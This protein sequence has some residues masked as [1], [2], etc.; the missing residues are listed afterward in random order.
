MNQR[1]IIIRH[2]ANDAHNDVII[3]RHRRINGQFKT[4]IN[5]R[6]IYVGQGQP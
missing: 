3:P 1:A 2:S 5:V 6:H 4:A